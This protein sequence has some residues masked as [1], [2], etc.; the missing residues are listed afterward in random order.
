[1]SHRIANLDCKLKV[2]VG[3]RMSKNSR[4]MKLSEDLA[5]IVGMS[6]A[7]H[8]QCIKQLWT[9]INTN[10]LR[11][12]KNMEFFIPDAKL[13][14]IFGNNRIYGLD[15]ILICQF[16]SAHLTNIA[17]KEEAP[18]ATTKKPKT[19]TTSSFVCTSGVLMWGQL[20]CVL[21]ARSKPKNG[22]EIKYDGTLGEPKPRGEGTAYWVTHHYRCK[23]EIGKWWKRV[24]KA[25]SEEEFGQFGIGLVFCHENYSP[26]DIVTKAI[27]VD[28]SWKP[29]WDAEVI[30]VNRY[31]WSWHHE[32][33]FGKRWKGLGTDVFLVD[34]DWALEGL[35]DDDV[36]YDNLMYMLEREEEDDVDTEKLLRLQKAK[37]K[38]EEAT[39]KTIQLLDAEDN[40]CGL[41]SQDLHEAEW[42]FGRLVFNTNRHLIGF[43]ICPWDGV[44]E[45]LIKIID[46]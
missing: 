17:E 13:A 14:K 32:T 16:L 15:R 4:P 30:Y 25:E 21:D 12:P 33:S 10:N 28:F 24:Y 27:T 35:P 46:K 1:M 20:D 9:Y 26:K 40:V 37:H 31:D 5:S 34:S 22:Q 6:E 19:S 23:A 18:P 43:C 45:H 3:V 44:F 41:L 42:L 38:K 2:K 7:S 8:V 29:D 11:D 36:E 39:S